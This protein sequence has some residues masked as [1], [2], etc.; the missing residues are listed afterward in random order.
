[1]TELY[2]T[3]HHAHTYLTR[4]IKNIKQVKEQKH[5][6]HNCLLTMSFHR[7]LKIKDV[8]FV[9]NLINKTLICFICVPSEETVASRLLLYM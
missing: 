4:H 2:N 8:I 9:I 1:M 7:E 6:D 3:A 5:V